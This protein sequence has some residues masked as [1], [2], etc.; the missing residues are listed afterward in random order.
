MTSKTTT[1]TTSPKTNRNKPQ[2]KSHR[3]NRQRRLQKQLQMLLLERHSRKCII[4]HHPEREAIE[5]EFLHWRAP[6]KL[7]E[8]YN[9]A[10]YR[11]LYRHAR[12]AGILLQRREN[13]HS[14]LDAF[15]EAVDDV[16]F[17]PDSI[18]RAMRAYSCID[19]HGRWTEIPTQVHIS[20]FHDGHPT[21]SPA[22]YAKNDST[23]ASDI[24]DIVPQY[25]NRASRSDATACAA[26]P[27]Q[28]V[29]TG[30]SNSLYSGRTVTATACAV[31]SA[32]AFN[33]SN[34]DTDFDG[35]PDDEP[36]KNATESGEHNE[37]SKAEALP[38]GAPQ[39]PPG[40]SAT[41]TTRAV[42]SK[43][44]SRSDATACA[45]LPR[46]SKGS[47]AQQ[48][49]KM[50]LGN[51]RNVTATTCAAPPAQ[52][53]ACRATQVIRH[54]PQQETGRRATATAC[55]VSSAQA[56]P[57]NTVRGPNPKDRSPSGRTDCAPSPA[58][59]DACRATQVNRSQL[60]QETGRSATITTRAVSSKLA[61][62]SDATAC[63]VP[64]AQAVSGVR[65]NSNHRG[66][67]VTATACAGLPRPSRGSPAQNDACRATQVNRSQLQQET[68]RC[69]TATACADS[70][71]QA[72]PR[73]EVRGH[74]PKDRS[75]SD[76]TDCAGLPRPSRGSPAQNDACRATQVNRHQPQ[77]ET[78]RRAT[79]T[80][81]AVSSKLASRSDA[82]ACA[83]PLALFPQ[84]WHRAAMLPL[85]QSH[86]R[87]LFQGCD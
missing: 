30:S 26:S 18:L 82:T 27:A 80:T 38:Q 74:N 63:A 3:I 51:G 15:V 54:Q 48:V 47:P 40:R 19:H 5:E 45:G 62:R 20:T 56:P 42:S 79:I 66:R 70:P 69:A 49:P 6:W 32:Q 67:N 31:S 34:S 1:K 61:S 25:S 76:R 72:L 2:E 83:V 8:D 39:H 16:K 55:A 78:G 36:D 73:N 68:G 57:R 84:S 44:A 50:P 22:P 71:A 87:K 35:D 9:L 7:A 53:D 65:L 12:A 14:A 85:A 58:Q 81:R 28:S 24:L 41:I 23:A 29:S 13:L 60:Q 10:D 43:L 37:A 52:N 86:P 17:T 75:P 33:V 11:T 77:Q 46:P 4:C 64:P 59:N 21:Q